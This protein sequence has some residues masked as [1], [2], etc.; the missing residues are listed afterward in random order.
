MNKIIQFLI[1]FLLIYLI[2][3]NFNKTFFI[4]KL[5]IYEPITDHEVLSYTIVLPIVEWE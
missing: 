3:F 5:N 2:L 1:P 4:S